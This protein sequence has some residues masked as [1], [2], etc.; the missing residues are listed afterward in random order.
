MVIQ[1]AQYLDQET[2]LKKL[3]FIT[4][5]EVEDIMKETMQEESDR[6]VSEEN[7]PF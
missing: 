2:I 1:A 5:D 4:V 3:P 7:M 6:V